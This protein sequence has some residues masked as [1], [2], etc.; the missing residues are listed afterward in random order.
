MQQTSTDPATASRIERHLCEVCAGLKTESQVEEEK[1]TVRA[2]VEKNRQANAETARQIHDDLFQSKAA[3]VQSR[4]VI[5][6]GTVSCGPN[7]EL[8]VVRSKLPAVDPLEVWREP[9]ENGKNHIVRRVR[10]HEVHLISWNADPNQ[11]L[12]NIF[13][14]FPNAVA[15]L[16]LEQ[17]VLSVQ[18]EDSL[19]PDA[20]QSRSFCKFAASLLMYCDRVARKEFIF[21][22]QKP[23]WITA[24]L[25]KES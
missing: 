24:G 15:K 17:G 20:F 3:I 11:L 23:Q 14:P 9:G 4:Q 19:F 8:T 22:S 18:N 5:V 25:E 13:E 10:D 12:A 2:A 1:A 7:I 21:R 16:D 6:C